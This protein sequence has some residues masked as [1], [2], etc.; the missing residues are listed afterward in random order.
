MDLNQK[1]KEKTLRCKMRIN[2]GKSIRIIQ[3]SKAVSK[4]F[5]DIL[6]DMAGYKQ[7]TNIFDVRSLFS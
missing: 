2:M 4:L 1:F 5:M 6:S 3:S 7:R